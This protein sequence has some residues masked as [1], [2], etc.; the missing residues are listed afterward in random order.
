MKI[1]LEYFLNKKNI[2]LKYFCDINSIKSYDELVLYCASKRFIPVSKSFYDDQIPQLAEKKEEAK[3]QNETEKKVTK[4][5]SKTS[6]TNTTRRSRKA[7][8]KKSVRNGD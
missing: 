3:K 6:K 1:E 4:A 2:K 8:A 5:R 7:P